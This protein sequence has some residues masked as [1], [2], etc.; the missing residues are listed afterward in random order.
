MPAP[1]AGTLAEGAQ[2]RDVVALQTALAAQGFQPGTIDGEFG[3][4][5]GTA[6]TNFQRLRNLAVTG[7]ADPATLQ[8]LGLAQVE[9]AAAPIASAA[10]IAGQVGSTTMQPQDVLKIVLD[11]LVAGKQA[12]AAPASPTPVTSAAGPIDISQVLQ[13]AIAALAG[14]PVAGA[15]VPSPGAPTG[16]AAPVLSTI[17]KVFGGEALAGKK[18]M[19]SVIAYVI[20][21]IL[22]AV[23]VAGT[24]TG[25]TATPTGSILTTLIGAFGALGGLSKIDRVVQTLGVIANQVTAPQK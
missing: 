22:Q 6:V 14:K 9:T 11:A 8:A 15:V 10:P 20:L 18:T 24:A 21:A 12:G 16:T 7:T 1:S 19:L 23:G 2:G 13:V 4:L 17:D 5:T 25:A 3:P